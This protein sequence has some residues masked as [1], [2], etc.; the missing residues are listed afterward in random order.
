MRPTSL[1]VSQINI[2]YVPV[3]VIL[4]VCFF[5]LSVLEFFET[6]YNKEEDSDSSTSGGTG[7]TQE[8]E[9][10]EIMTLC[11]C[12]CV[13]ET[14]FNRLMW[15]SLPMSTASKGAISTKDRS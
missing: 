3:H 1:A 7:Q 12:V 11:V 4:S 13:C 14:V 9:V 2:L 5:V 8:W 6:D 15:N 10:K